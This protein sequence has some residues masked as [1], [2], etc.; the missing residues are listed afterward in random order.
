[1]AAKSR[2]VS[3][4]DFKFLLGVGFIPLTYSCYEEATSRLFE[5][6]LNPVEVATITGHKD[7]RMLMRYTHLRA[8]DLVGRLG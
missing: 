1:M 7:T 5:K 4:K 2:K 6:G 8:E 3:L